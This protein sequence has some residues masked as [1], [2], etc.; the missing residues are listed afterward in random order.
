MSAM[1]QVCVICMKEVRVSLCTGSTVFLYDVVHE[2]LDNSQ[3]HDMLML[4]T[5]G[6]K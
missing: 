2:N 3:M 6:V 1:H 5:F 4:H